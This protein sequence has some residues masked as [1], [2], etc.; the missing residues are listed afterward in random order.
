MLVLELDEFITN[1]ARIVGL[2]GA[3]SMKL[4]EV[5]LSVRPSRH[6]DAARRCGGFAAAGPAARRYRSIAARPELNSKCEQ[7]HAV[8]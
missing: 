5:R 2:Y 8:S 1:T 4:S 3:R 6:S 7:Y